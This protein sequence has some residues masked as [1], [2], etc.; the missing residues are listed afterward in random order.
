MGSI[1]YQA[2][3]SSLGISLVTFDVSFANNKF[4]AGQIF[5]FDVICENLGIR[6]TT[7]YLTLTGRNASL[8]VGSQQNY[9]QINETVFKIPFHFPAASLHAK[10]TKPVSVTIDSSASGFQL[11]FD[12]SV[13]ATGGVM[14]V[15]GKWNETTNGY[16]VNTR[17]GPCV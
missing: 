3:D 9:I 8:M 11:D 1:A 17:L 14:G 4:V 13:I 15:Q 16:V 5:E 6:E 7:F 12:S 10:E 2:Y